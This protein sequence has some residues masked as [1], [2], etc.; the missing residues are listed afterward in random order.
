MKNCKY[1]I[2][3]FLVCC[4][5]LSGCDRY[6]D[7]TPKGKRL[8]T[9]IDDY[10]QWLNSE[11]LLMGTNPL[12]IYLGDNVDV[13]NAANT[14]QSQAELVYTWSDQFSTDLNAPPVFW[15][16]HYA[17]INLFNTVIAGIDKATGGTNSRKRSLKAEAL[18][19]RA[20]E[21][22]YLVNEYAIPYDPAT[23]DQD[24][25]V[26]FVTSN[27]VTEAVP[28][29]STTAEMYRHIIGDINA[30]LPDLPVDNSNNR[31]RGSVAAA[32]SLLARVY[33]YSG[34]Y[35][36]AQKN[37]ELAL[38]STKAVMIDFNGTLPTSN[39]VSIH[40]DVIYGRIALGQ[41]STTLD[42]MRTFESSDLRVR[43]LYTSADSYRFITR[44]ATNF[45]PGGIT[46]VFTYVNTGT[47]VQEMKLIAAEAAARENN[48]TTALQYLD[49]VR[50]NRFATTGYVR[51]TSANQEDVLQEVLEE[52]SHELPL[53][54]LRWFDMRRLDK[55]NRMGAVNRYNAQGTVIATLEPHSKRYTLKIPVQV[56]SFNP[57]M[58]QNP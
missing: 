35:K 49:D 50:K 57:G 40:P 37:A 28:A 24:L 29:R 56:M 9:T 36:D 21:Y 32:Y 23:A 51:Y 20:F 58:P 14:P 47:S 25:A 15:G 39:L 17:K 45:F 6:L 2:V 53:N 19:G 30:A 48:L 18:L 7:I 34:N 46:P 12:L 3:G 43:K 33:F 8:L 31:Y 54:G 42:F 41:G 27:D 16:E 4:L 1:K 22:F 10:D 44:G 5:L 11:S 55:E 13:V 52:R 26:P 38:T